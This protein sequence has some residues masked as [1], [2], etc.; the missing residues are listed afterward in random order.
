MDKYPRPWHCKRPEEYED[1]IG[2]RNVYDADGIEIMHG[3]QQAFAEFIVSRVNDGETL[4]DM[5]AQLKATTP[6][7]LRERMEE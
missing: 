3:Y 2:V 5:R 7:C 1:S 4:D 6:D